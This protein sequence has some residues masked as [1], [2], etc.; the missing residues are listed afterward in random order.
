VAFDYIKNADAILYVTYYNHAFSRADREFLLQLGRIKDALELDKMFFVINAADLA[1][2]GQELVEVQQHVEKGLLAHGIRQPRLFAVSSRMALAA[3]QSRQTEPLAA[4][5]FPALTQALAAFTYGE[6]AVQAELSVRLLLRRAS[7]ALA[8]RLRLAQASGEQKEQEAASVTAKR[9]ELGQWLA[10]PQSLVLVQ[11]EL[12]NEI[13]ELCFYIRQR[14]TFRFGE[15]YGACFNA[16]TLRVDD[17][18][19]TSQMLRA[20]WLE[21]TALIA[22]TLSQELLAATLPVERYLTRKL[23]AYE[24]ELRQ[25]IAA[26]LPGFS[27]SGLVPASFPAP[28]VD[29][30]VGLSAPDARWLR[31]M[32][33]N[34]RSFFEQ[35]GREALKQ[36]LEQRMLPEIS[37]YLEQHRLRLRAFY[38]ETLATAQAEINHILLQHMEDYTA[39]L[40]S[41]LA[42]D[43]DIPVL[44]GKLQQMQERLAKL[45]E[46]SVGS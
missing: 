5:G 26:G 42:T 34:S 1:A 27:A 13:D 35:G 11:Q 16:A 6:V 33:K 14:F 24:L 12:N 20:A 41:A 4:S 19:E 17:H 8:E 23:T 10:K 40:L 30:H 38:T 2:N 45:S 32:Y 29:E 36:A 25:D 7:D 46:Q 9:A 3:T 44:V 22:Y 18:R 43:V 31:Q 28:H 15:L 37:E 39:G 21:N